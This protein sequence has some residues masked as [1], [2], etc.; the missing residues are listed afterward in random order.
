M[1][2]FD[3]RAVRKAEKGKALSGTYK[4][5]V[6]PGLLLEGDFR[7]HLETV[8]FLAKSDTE[9]HKWWAVNTGNLEREFAEIVSSEL[10]SHFMNRL[11]SGETVEFPN[12]YAIQ[13]VKG[14]I[15]VRWAG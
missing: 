12:R 8:H 11:E 2:Q 14:K 3:R 6:T 5:I 1:A 7:G 10:A 4:L 15:G 13:E 9:E